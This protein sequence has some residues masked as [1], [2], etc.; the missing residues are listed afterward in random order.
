MARRLDDEEVL[1]HRIKKDAAPTRFRDQA[2]VSL[3]PT[4]VWAYDLQADD[5]ETHNAELIEAIERQVSPRPPLGPGETRQTDH[6]PHELPGFRVF[7]S[8]TEKAV[9]R[10]FDFLKVH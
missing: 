2:V 4:H 3:F 7:M 10:A 9:R 8:Y 5:A 1:G 6:I